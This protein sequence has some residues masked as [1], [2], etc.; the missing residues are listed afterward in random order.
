MGVH[1]RTIERMPV[2]VGVVLWLL[3]L[4]ILSRAFK[5]PSEATVQI[6]RLQSNIW[7]ILTA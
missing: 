6:R 2:G 5:K 3:P 7:K 1:D 4:S